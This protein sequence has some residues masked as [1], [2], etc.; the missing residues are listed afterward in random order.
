MWPEPVCPLHHRNCIPV[1]GSW[2]ASLVRRDCWI[3]LLRAPCMFA[4]VPRLVV[5]PAGPQVPGVGPEVPQWRKGHI[6]TEITIR[7]ESCPT[8]FRSIKLDYLRLVPLL[9]SDLEVGSPVVARDG[10]CNIGSVLHRCS[11]NNVQVFRTL[12]RH[13]IFFRVC[14][15]GTNV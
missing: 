13:R 11:T 10:Y 1:L 14:V 2:P 4:E 12:S 9:V 6:D 15:C 3:R 5:P 8:S 7:I